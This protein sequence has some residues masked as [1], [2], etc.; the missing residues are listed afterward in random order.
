MT[1]MRKI[2]RGT[3]SV[4]MLRVSIIHW[5]VG[6]KLFLQ[7]SV[8]WGGCFPFWG[9][10]TLASHQIS[11]SRKLKLTLA[12]LKA[13]LYSLTPIFMVC[14]TRANACSIS[15]ICCVILS[16]ISMTECLRMSREHLILLGR[17]WKHR[18]PYVVGRKVELSQVSW[19]QTSHEEIRKT[20]IS[21]ACN[22]PQYV[23]EKPRPSLFLRGRWGGI[24]NF[25]SPGRIS[26]KGWWAGAKCARLGS[27][28]NSE[29]DF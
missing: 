21:E 1:T 11:C 23:C 6:S 26:G 2:R 25:E 15:Y 14:L 12:R 17:C 5:S 18:P 19:G 24:M 20:N 9:S 3:R 16:I 8:F 22:T 28:E 27:L 29:I 13:C 7:V 4:V 10:L